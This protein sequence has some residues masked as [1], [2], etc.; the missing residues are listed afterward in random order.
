M[1]EMRDDLHAMDL[2]VVLQVGFQACSMKQKAILIQWG[3]N[4]SQVCNL[5]HLPFH[6]IRL[7]PSLPCTRVKAIHLFSRPLF[8]IPSSKNAQ[9][10]D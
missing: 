4:L 5:S 2:K 6:P 9:A 3:I 8:T 7:T 1:M 10:Y